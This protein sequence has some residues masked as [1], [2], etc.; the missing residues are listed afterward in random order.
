[1]TSSGQVPQSSVVI[2]QNFL[3][4]AH[5]VAAGLD[6]PNAGHVADAP[7]VRKRALATRSNVFGVFGSKRWTMMPMSILFDQ[8]ALS[9]MS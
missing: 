9:A 2:T 7:M 6:V 5:R 8:W 4:I 1:V 3:E